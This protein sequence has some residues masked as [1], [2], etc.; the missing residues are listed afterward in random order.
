MMSDMF[1]CFGKHQN[2]DRC[3]C[4][5]DEGFCIIKTKEIKEE[6]EKK[7]ADGLPVRKCK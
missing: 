1:P 5:G 6:M 4:C 3:Y 2:I 7:D